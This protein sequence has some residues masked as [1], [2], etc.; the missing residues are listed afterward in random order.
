MRAT[1]LKANLAFFNPGGDVV[2]A[3]AFVD[4]DFDV[5]F[6]DGTTRQVTRT[7]RFSLGRSDGVWQVMGYRICCADPAAVQAEDDVMRA[8]LRVLR[9]GLRLLPLVARAGAGGAGVGRPTDDH[10]PDEGA[11]RGGVRL[12]RRRRLDPGAR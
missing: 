9:H 1:R 6:E 11:A 7:G 5:T 10:R 3:S 8:A 12:R 2:G 4:L